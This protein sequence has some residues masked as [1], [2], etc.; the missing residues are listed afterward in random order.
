MSELR[1]VDGT[2]EAGAPDNV[3]RQ[4]A[5]L[6]QNPGSTIVIDDY[7]WHV[8]RSSAGILLG[9]RPELGDLIDFLERR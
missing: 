3:K 2:P 6:E 1:A 8:A 4:Q 7:R 9:R 5:W